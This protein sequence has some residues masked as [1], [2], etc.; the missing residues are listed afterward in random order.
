MPIYKAKGCDIWKLLAVLSML[1]C[2]RVDGLRSKMASDYSPLL[3]A[4][5]QALATQAVAGLK[6]SCRYTAC[7]LHSIHKATIPPCSNPLFNHIMLLLLF[8]RKWLENIN[9][10]LISWSHL[11]VHST[12][13]FIHLCWHIIHRCTE[14]EMC[15]S[16]ICCGVKR[17]SAQPSQCKNHPGWLYI[18]YIILSVLARFFNLTLVKCR[19]W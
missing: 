8:S 2:G 7:C 13:E 14:P 1:D 5:L 10:N 16:F 9:K 4:C 3:P 15:C 12:I 17:V 6:A 19:R 18:C 11:L